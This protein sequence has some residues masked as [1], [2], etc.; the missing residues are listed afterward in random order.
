MF[1]NR[2]TTPTF[3]VRDISLPSFLILEIKIHILND[4]FVCCCA[5]LH[6]TL[7]ILTIAPG[8]GDAFKEDQEQQTHSTG[9]VV[10]KQFE[11]IDSTLVTEKCI[12]IMTKD[13][14]CRNRITYSALLVIF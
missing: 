4:H 11:H 9:R 6:E 10:V 13:L 3:H 14:L 12:S 7:T 8:Y 1:S 5:I 2:H